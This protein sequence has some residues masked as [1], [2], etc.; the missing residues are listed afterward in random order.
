MSGIQSMPTFTIPLN[1]T[2]LNGT[3]NMSTFDDGFYM[4]KLRRTNSKLEVHMGVSAFQKVF[5]SDDYSN[6]VDMAFN[7][8]LS[9]F[10]AQFNVHIGTWI[11]QNSLN[12]DNDNSGD[13]TD[14]VYSYDPTSIYMSI[15]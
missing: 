10:P 2:Q 5:D 14:D 1:I 13:S 15:F 8:T 7:D 9:Q 6:T 3:N 12:T 11:D 4:F